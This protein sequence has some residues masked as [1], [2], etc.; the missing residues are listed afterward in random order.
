MNIE[1]KIVVLLT[2]IQHQLDVA[3]IDYQINKEHL[4]GIWEYL[5]TEGY[6]LVSDAVFLDWMN[7]WSEFKHKNLGKVFRNSLT[8]VPMEPLDEF[9]LWENYERRHGKLGDLYEEYDNRK[10]L[11]KGLQKSIPLLGTYLDEYR[12]IFGK[13]WYPYEAGTSTLNN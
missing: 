2:L 5:D 6:T 3:G 9:T 13:E 11:P 7:G 1:K 10:Q 8:G 4:N 12:E